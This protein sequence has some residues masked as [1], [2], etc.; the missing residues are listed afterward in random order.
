MGKIV[1]ITKSKKKR[2]TETSWDMETDA[3]GRDIFERYFVVEI[4][5]YIWKIF[6]KDRVEI[7]LEICDKNIFGR[8][9]IRIVE[10]YL[11]QRFDRDIFGTK[12]WRGISSKLKSYIYGI[13][14]SSQKCTFLPF[15]YPI[16][17]HI[18]KSSIIK[19]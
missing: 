12:F 8:Y 7:Y 17:L 11:E 15:L 13:K 18:L 9:F 5:E 2:E 6:S 1:N 14:Q 16:L 3:R 10:I 4:Y 19:P